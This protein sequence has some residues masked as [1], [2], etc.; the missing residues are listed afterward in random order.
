MS[1]NTNMLN[2]TEGN[3]TKLLVKFSI[4]MLIGNVFQ[5]IYN[6]VDS[7]VVGQY[8]GAN[9]LAAIGATGSVVFLFIALCNGIGSGGGVIVSQFF[10]A[11]N[12]KKVRN[13]LTNVAY[14]MM[15]MAILVCIVSSIITPWILRT[16]RTPVEILDDSIVYMRMMCFGLPL[17]AV[18]N[19]SASMLRALGD[20][21]GPLYFLIVTSI[22]NVFLDLLFVRG[23]NMGVFG[24]AFATVIAQLIAG[25]CCMIYAFCTNEY[26]HLKIEDYKLDVNIAHDTI[27]L[28]IPM[29]LQFALIAISSMGLQVVVNSFGAIAVAAFTATSRIEQLVH[30]P[31]TS[32]SAALATYSGQNYGAMKKDRLREGFIK[33]TIIMMIMTA[34]LVLIMQLGGRQIVSLFV[35]DEGVI[36]M[37]ARGLRITSIFYAVLGMIY[38]TRGVQNGIGDATFALLN[39][40][41]EV[42]AR[43]LLPIFMSKD[44]LLGVWGIWWSAGTV[45]LVS[46]VFCFWR[47][48]Y[49][50]KKYNM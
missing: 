31:Y 21:K 1:K 46:C 18:Y 12:D 47:Y 8:V 10:G 24:A 17:V 50:R 27:R 25:V 28:G 3:V 2:M 5:Q 45:W 13:T 20:S 33:S 7:V 14:L 9:A 26:F 15:G 41:V 34:V 42:I 16:L 49:Y 44:Y 22:I 4:P 40:I 32:L 29:S 37:G 19:Y 48:I 23:F 35:P 30:Q 11:G 6:L 38:V 39:G 43:V 36:E